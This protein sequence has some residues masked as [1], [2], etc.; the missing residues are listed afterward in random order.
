MS[1]IYIGENPKVIFSLI[2]QAEKQCLDLYKTILFIRLPWSHFQRVKAAGNTIAL[3]L[4]KKQTRAQGQELLRRQLLAD[5]AAAISSGRP[6]PLSQ[7]L[8]A[9]RSVVINDGFEIFA[10]I[11]EFLENINATV[12]AM[13]RR[14]H[15]LSARD[16]T[17]LRRVETLIAAATEMYDTRRY[18]FKLRPLAHICFNC[19]RDSSK[20]KIT[21]DDGGEQISI[22][23]Y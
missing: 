23:A 15:K 10:A 7:Q 21:I 5:G 1:L 13:V 3:Q 4:E 6:S 14:R 9:L 18:P 20:C 22:V 17:T 16:D 11:E 8:A 19:Y 12:A 2:N